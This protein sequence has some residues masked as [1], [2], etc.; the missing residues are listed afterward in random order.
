MVAALT[1]TGGSI[2]PDLGEVPE[3]V[4]L[5][6]GLVGWFGGFLTLLGAYVILAP[7]RLGGFEVMAAG[8]ESFTEGRSV[9]LRLPSASLEHRLNRALREILERGNVP[10]PDKV[11]PSRVF[12]NLNRLE[13]D[14]AGDRFYKQADGSYC[15]ELFSREKAVGCK[16]TFQPLKPPTRQ[17]N[18]GVVRGSDDETLFYY[19]IPR[20][21]VT[22]TVIE[23]GREHEL[24]EASG[25]YDHEFGVGY[26]ERYDDEAEAKLPAEQQAALTA[27]I[28][29]GRLGS[30][31]DI[32]AAV[33]F[34][35][36]PQAGYIT[37][38]TLHV[39]GGMYMV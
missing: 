17:G 39:N 6:R 1:T 7:R 12:V 16:L 22:G 27:Q 26:E 37:G 9:D 11:F 25:W 8:A 24:R 5:W 15:L 4:H 34:L 28:A 20:C 32:A 36:S 38:E 33:A 30:P 19:Y 14:Y 13:L 21:K 3:P 35:A 18:E 10:T 2:Y 31:E 29:L 23:S